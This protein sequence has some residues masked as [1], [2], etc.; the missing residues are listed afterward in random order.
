MFSA[1]DFSRLVCGQKIRGY[2]RDDFREENHPIVAMKIGDRA[3]FEVYGTHRYEVPF[4]DL[5]GLW[6]FD[7]PSLL[8]SGPAPMPRTETL[9]RIATRAMDRLSP[10]DLFPCRAVGV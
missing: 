5:Q 1:R 6:S 8:I 2:D 10:A 4:A 7:L 9:I 3:V